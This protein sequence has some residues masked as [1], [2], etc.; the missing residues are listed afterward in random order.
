MVTGGPVWLATET[1]TATASPACAPC[2]TVAA[3]NWYCAGGTEIAEECLNDS[4]PP[5]MVEMK[6]RNGLSL[7][8]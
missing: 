4:L 8:L 2:G 1:V 5:A 7:R 3:V 6:S